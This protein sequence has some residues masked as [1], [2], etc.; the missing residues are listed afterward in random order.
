MTGMM[1]RT[2]ISYTVV[3]IALILIAVFALTHKSS[4][5]SAATATA[6][7]HIRWLLSHQPVSVFTRATQVFAAELAKDTNGQMTLT[8]VTPEDL[9][10][11]KG[12]VPNAEIFKELDSGDVQIAS[13]YTVALGQQDPQ[14]W[15][16][17]LPYLF[18]SYESMT[19][20]LDGPTGQQLLNSLGNGTSTIRGLAFTMSGGYRII[21]SKDKAIT[22]VSDVKGM[23]IATSG[24]PVA[25]ATLRALGA[26]PVAVDL[27]SAGQSFDPNTIDGVETT[28]SRLAEVLGNETA[29]TK[30]I[31]ETD[32]SMFLTAIISSKSFYDS[33]SP[34][35][36]AALQK[37]ALDAAQVERQDSIALAT[38]VKSQLESQG[39]TVSAL[40]PAAQSAFK[41]ATQSV[42]TQFSPVVGADIVQSLIN[43]QK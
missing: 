25:E 3:A 41:S 5:A 2:R 16:L 19:P 42:Y 30:Y 28:Y 39:S 35:D 22:S 8:V 4:T 36:Q 10:Y 26:I 29:Y 43:G 40:T 17:T 9:G 31:N 15:A 7:V 11:T 13:A 24:G 23:H 27:E 14:M 34:Q 6:P 1:T 21:A 18:G 20:V 38:Q 37:A 12:D 32:H 33:L